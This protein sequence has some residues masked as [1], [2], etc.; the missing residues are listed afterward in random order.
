M[1]SVYENIVDEAKGVCH[2]RSQWKVMVSGHTI[3]KK[4]CSMY[5]STNVVNICQNCT[6]IDRPII[7]EKVLKLATIETI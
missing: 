3:E 7:D 1:T 5:H 6:Q 2:H 4:A